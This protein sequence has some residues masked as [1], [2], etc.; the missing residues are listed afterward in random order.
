MIEI[1]DH[2][3]II[4]LVNDQDFV[5]FVKYSLDIGA[6]FREVNLKVLEGQAI[7]IQHVITEPTGTTKNFVLIGNLK[8]GSA[9]TVNLD[10]DHVF[11]NNVLHGLIFRV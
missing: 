4:I 5:T 1:N 7:K 2:G 6:T 9:A 8:N 3:A 11:I 10:F